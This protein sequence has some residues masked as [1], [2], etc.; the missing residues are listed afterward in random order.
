MLS[1]SSMTVFS[2]FGILTAAMILYALAA[3]LLVL[4][5]VVLTVAEYRAPP[6]FP[7]RADVGA[8]GAPDNVW[9]E[10]NE[11]MPNT[12]PRRVVRRVKKVRRR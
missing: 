10:N 8:S 3:T 9:G 5:A 7:P 12:P 4:P 11:S 6:A 2:Q 1:F